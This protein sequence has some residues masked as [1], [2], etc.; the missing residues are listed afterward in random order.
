MGRLSPGSF[1]PS[2][3]GQALGHLF[4]PGPR[5]GG[6]WA[7]GSLPGEGQAEL[8]PQDRLTP[9]SHFPST[10]PP[11]GQREGP[12]PI[13]KQE[14]LPRTARP[15]PGPRL[16]HETSLGSHKGNA[17]R[18]SGTRQGKTR[19]GATVS[20]HRPHWF[21]C[22]SA[23]GLGLWAAAGGGRAESS[24]TVRGREPGP[25]SPGLRILSPEHQWEEDRPRP[26]VGTCMG[27]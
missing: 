8:S 4:C 12:L 15:L 23:R 11:V 20:W 16:S 6:S 19:Q 21:G 14:T 17:V 27:C 2:E 3:P 24:P 25:G 10:F 18:V 22:A 7:P 9:S 1:S 13:G 5:S 26:G